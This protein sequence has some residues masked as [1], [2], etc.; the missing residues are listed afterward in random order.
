LHEE[1]RFGE[2][3]SHIRSLVM[4]EYAAQAQQS[5]RISD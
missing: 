4:E 1:P 5:A 3:R 2:L